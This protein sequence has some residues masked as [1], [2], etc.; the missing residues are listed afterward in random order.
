MSRSRRRFIRWAS[1]LVAGTSVLLPIM[2]RS[3]AAASSDPNWRN[4]VNI[5]EKISLLVHKDAIREVRHR[6][7]WALDTQDWK[8]FESLF[9]PEVETDFSAL[10]APPGRMTPADLVAMFKHAFR[11]HGTR[12]QQLYSNF[13]IDVAGANATCTSY[14][15]G[16]HHTPGF[17]GGEH[18]EIRAAYHDKL[19]YQGDQWRITG[20]KLVVFFA[21]GNFAMVS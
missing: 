3:F 18:F 6:F 9:A 10:G 20:T 14:L 15:F 13:Q 12:T 4:H 16:Q 7:G 17:S 8:L 11:A 1:A 19:A 2:S 5:D 21:T